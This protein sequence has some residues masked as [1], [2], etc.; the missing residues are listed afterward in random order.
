MSFLKPKKIRHHALLPK[1]AFTCH[2]AADGPTA[3]LP[4][5]ALWTTASAE[6]GLLSHAWGIQALARCSVNLVNEGELGDKPPPKMVFSFLVLQPGHRQ[7][8]ERVLAEQDILPPLLGIPKE[9]Q[10]PFSCEEPWTEPPLKRSDGVM[11]P[12]K[13][14]AFSYNSV[15]ALGVRLQASPSSV[16]WL[17][18]LPTWGFSPS[19]HGVPRHVNHTLD[20][21]CLMVRTFSAKIL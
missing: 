15:T 12:R 11:H 9:M 3:Q 19:L 7:Q 18:R 8:K 16:G 6:P 1:P 13:A 5:S 20:K 21:E 4:T 10:C 14:E 17:V 2:S